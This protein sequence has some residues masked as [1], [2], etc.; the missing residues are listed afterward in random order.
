MPKQSS[1]TEHGQAYKVL[2]DAILDPTTR[3]AAKSHP[4]AGPILKKLS[5]R[6]VNNLREMAKSQAGSV[7]PQDG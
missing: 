2:L 5:N 1:A 6:D 7:C 3:D 4:I